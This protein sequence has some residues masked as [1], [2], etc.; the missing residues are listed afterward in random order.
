MK[1]RS[2]STI[3][4]LKHQP[5][6]FKQYLL[7][8]C[9]HSYNAQLGPEEGIVMGWVTGSYLAFNHR[10]GMKDYLSNMMGQEVEVLAKKKSLQ[11]RSR[12]TYV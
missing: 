5:S 8:A 9:V 6:S 7:H 10:D 11:N 3:A 4:Q 12:G 1:I 2:S